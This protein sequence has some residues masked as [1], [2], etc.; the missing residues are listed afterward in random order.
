MDYKHVND[1][2]VMY[3]IKENDE[4]SRTLLLKKYSPIINK[5]ASKYLTYAKGFGIEFDDLV[6]EGFIALNTAIFNFND[7]NNVLFYTYACVCVE[8]HLISYCKR[9]N[10]KKNYYLNNSIF[11]DC[12]SIC[13]AN[14]YLDNFVNELSAEEVF[15]NFKNSFDIKYSSVLELRY[16]GFTYREIS[17]LLGISIGT[18]DVRLSRIRSI[19]HGKCKFNI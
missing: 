4:E 14:S 5:I 11:D 16:N 18:V 17:E 6:Q 3:M 2:E 19:L 12:Y 15:I 13:D 7:D 1:Y 10:S 9:A 8:R